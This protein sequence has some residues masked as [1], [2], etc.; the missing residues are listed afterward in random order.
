MLV[1]LLAGEITAV[2]LVEGN[3]DLFGRILAGT[4]ILAGLGTV[5][6]PILYRLYGEHNP[7]SPVST[8][9]KMEMVCPRCGEGQ[10]IPAGDSACGKCGLKF[11]LEIEEP[12]CPGCGYLLY[13][14]TSRQ[15][16]E[17]GRVVAKGAA[18]V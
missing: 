13:Q 9:L 10:T 6:L 14:L 11:R 18:H 8:E 3:G 2:I 7:T 17:C 15:C 16:P 4:A 5:S 12:R 1:A